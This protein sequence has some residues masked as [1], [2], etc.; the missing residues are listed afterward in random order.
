MVA[1]LHLMLE[2]LLSVV[3]MLSVSV[4][5][6]LFMVNIPAFMEP[7]LI[8]VVETAE[9][10]SAPGTHRHP[11]QNILVQTG[12]VL[13]V[14]ELD[15]AICAPP[16]PGAVLTFRMVL[17]ALLPGPSGE[18]RYPAT[19]RSVLTSDDA[20]RQL[21][22]YGGHTSVQNREGFQPHVFL[23]DVWH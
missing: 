18:L 17:P 22:L 3:E 23:R 6:L 11:N 19:R 21:L 12:Q 15:F 7:V 14:V 2:T 13:H 1:M 4:K 16:T 8:F 10:D 9:Q 5:L 20:I